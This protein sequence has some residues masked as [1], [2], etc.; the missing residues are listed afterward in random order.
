[1]RLDGRG[2]GKDCPSG[3]CAPRH[4]LLDPP[5]W[6]CVICHWQEKRQR[7]K[8][9]PGWGN[10]LSR[11]FSRLLSLPLFIPADQ[12]L[13]EEKWLVPLRM[14]GLLSPAHS[15]V[16]T[17][18]YLSQERCV[19]IRLRWPQ[20]PSVPLFIKTKLYSA[21]FLL[22]PTRHINR[23]LICSTTVSYGEAL[24]YSSEARR[25]KVDVVIPF[26]LAGE[27]SV[28]FYGNN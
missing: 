12:S 27:R 8:R 11:S 21:A 14:H 23:A 17:R 22:T 7:K 15:L 4:C 2:P 16:S 26:L 10:G 9:C 25:E 28:L 13:S 18:L 24:F 6:C 5:N 3:E 1:M 20:V 19:F